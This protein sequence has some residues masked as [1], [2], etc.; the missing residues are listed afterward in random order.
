MKIKRFKDYYDNE[1]LAY[2]FIE[3]LNSIINESDEI[4]YEPIRKKIFNDLKLNSNLA[5]TYGAGM[6]ALYPIVESLLKNLKLS[7]IEITPQSVILLTICSFTV[8][9]LE[10]KAIRDEMGI[11]KDCK[12]M[13][14]ELK[15]NG[16]GNGIV[17]KVVEVLKSFKSIFNIIYKHIGKSVSDLIDMFTYV[18]L[19]IPIMNG[20]SYIIGKYDL[21]I[22]TFIQNFAGLMLGVGTIITKRGISHILSKVKLKIDKNKILSKI[23]TSVK[24]GQNLKPGE[25][26]INEQ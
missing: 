5:L 11:R 6:N 3:S 26:M 13:L 4:H 7:S 9:Y 21:N 10:E 19:L 17:K 23:D 14:E 1:I 16:I 20:I 12:S 25:E 2:D 8:I 18:S 15:M 24:Q 22:D